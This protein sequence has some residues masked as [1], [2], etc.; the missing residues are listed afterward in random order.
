M[1]ARICWSTTRPP[2]LRLCPANPGNPRRNIEGESPLLRGK[3]QQVSSFMLRLGRH[4]PGKK[5]WGPA[6][7]KWLMLQKLEHRE[8]RIALEELLGA[9][10]QESERLEQA[11]LDAG[12]EW[13]LAEV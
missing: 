12:P 10:R 11:I 1:K 4:F 5:T 7:M 6:H 2:C 9:V 13:S 3:R 8:Q